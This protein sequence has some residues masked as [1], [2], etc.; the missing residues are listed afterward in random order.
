[1]GLAC[2]IKPSSSLVGSNTR[3]KRSLILNVLPDISKTPSSVRNIILEELNKY[4]GR[5]NLNGG[6]LINSGKTLSIIW[7]W[8]TCTE[9]DIDLTNPAE[10]ADILPHITPNTPL[11]SL[12]CTENIRQLLKQR[13]CDPLFQE[14]ISNA[15]CTAEEIN[16]LC[17]NLY[18]KDHPNGDPSWEERLQLTSPINCKMGLCHGKLF[19]I[20]D[21]PDGLSLKFAEDIARLAPY[22][23]VS[24]GPIVMRTIAEMMRTENGYKTQ[25]SCVPKIDSLN[26][27]KIDSA[28]VSASIWQITL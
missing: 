18:Q 24:C 15:L 28:Q 10:L 2:G 3:P 12:H 21:K 25:K 22:G 5:I 19:I 27:Q 16:E 9:E 7:H 11:S 23:A 13:M 4:I 1:M 14:V 26:T 8:G 20:D 6:I 17:K